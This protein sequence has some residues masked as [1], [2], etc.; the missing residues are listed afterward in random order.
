MP[1]YFLGNRILGSSPLKWWDDTT[2]SRAS[3]VLV[4]P[5]CGDSWARVVDN[6]SDWLP[7]RMGCHKHPW[8][9]SDVGG[10]FIFSWLQRIDALPPEVLRYEFELRMKEWE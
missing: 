9:T 1:T 8:A 10:S 6:P 4:C 3:W 5:T 2:L 7:V